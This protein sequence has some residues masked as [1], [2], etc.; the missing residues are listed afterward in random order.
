MKRS[1]G[2]I[3]LRAA[4]RP[5]T[6]DGES[7]MTPTPVCSE[8][9][10]RSPHTITAP[11]RHPRRRPP[12]STTQPSHPSPEPIQRFGH[13]PAPSLHNTKPS[14]AS[15]SRRTPPHPVSAALVAPSPVAFSPPAETQAAR[16]PVPVPRSTNPLY[17]QYWDTTADHV[18]RRA[19]LPRGS[20]A[21]HSPCQTEDSGTLGLTLFYFVRS[22]GIVDKKGC[23]ELMLYLL[24]MLHNCGVHHN[25]LT[26]A[27][28]MSLVLSDKQRDR[29]RR[30]SSGRWWGLPSTHHRITQTHSA[31]QRNVDHESCYSPSISRPPHGVVWRQVTSVNMVW[32][33]F[34]PFWLSFVWLEDDVK[35]PLD[36]WVKLLSMEA[37]PRPPFPKIP[38]LQRPQQPSSHYTR[39]RHPSPLPHPS[40]HLSV[41][42]ESDDAHTNH[43]SGDGV[44]V[45]VD[46]QTSIKNCG[47]AS[48]GTTRQR[49]GVV[50]RRLTDDRVLPN[51]YATKSGDPSGEERKVKVGRVTSRCLAWVETRWNNGASPDDDTSPSSQQ[52]RSTVRQREGSKLLRRPALSNSETPTPPQASSHHPPPASSHYPPPASSHHPPPASS[53]HPPSSSHHPPSS[54]H[55]PPSSS[56]H[57]PP[58]S[59]HP[60]SLSHHPPSSSH[61]PPSASHHPSSS[62]VHTER[63]HQYNHI[64]RHSREV[65]FDPTNASSPLNNNRDRGFTIT[66]HPSAHQI[67]RQPLTDSSDNIRPHRFKDVAPSPSSVASFDTAISCYSEMV[68]P[69]NYL[70]ER[71]NEGRPRCLSAERLNLFKAMFVAE[72]V[73]YYVRGCLSVPV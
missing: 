73:L 62:S 64:S 25:T 63:R 27:L 36:R 53:H 46:I 65:N 14:S 10:P 70:N 55:H 68:H 54:S 20:H 59:H 1:K 18:K 61:H 71:G 47:K 22:L 7:S 12:V 48:T 72:T 58:S 16:A 4:S 67:H 17:R 49:V 23:W 41:T 43:Q 57:P 24:N 40:T 34:V 15:R 51:N 56:H 2:T 8:H 28:L 69:H 42:K 31:H 6:D 45:G 5:T 30:A 44:G 21:R 52:G 29:A 50:G 35:V 11:Q 3:D 37:D 39:N 66:H 19:P 13:I 26:Q 60:R 32:C 33:M 38:R 9:T